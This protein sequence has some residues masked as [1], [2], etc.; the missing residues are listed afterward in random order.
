MNL[1]P[2]KKKK[3]LYVKICV[4]EWFVFGLQERPAFEDF[5]DEILFND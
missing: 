2:K 4:R 3:K 5:D 1:A